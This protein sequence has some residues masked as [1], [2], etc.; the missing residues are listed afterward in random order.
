MIRVIHSSIATWFMIW[1]LTDLIITHVH[2]ALIARC[3][4]IDHISPA[5][6]LS[7]PL[8]PSPLLQFSCSVLHNDRYG[9]SSVP[10]AH[11]LLSVL[12]TGGTDPPSGRSS[13]LPLRPDSR[14]GTPPLSQ[15]PK[16]FHLPGRSWS[17]PCHC[18]SILFY[19]VGIS[20]IHE[21]SFFHS[22]MFFK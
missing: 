14:P 4:S 20:K 13:P 11:V 19:S 10:P 12:L 21:N 8:N 2:L 1:N 7:I 17:T 3:A 18:Y 22:Q 15:T 16:H 6:I 5:D 9:C